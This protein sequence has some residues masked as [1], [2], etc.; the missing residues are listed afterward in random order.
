[1][2]R[3]PPRST[4]L[5]LLALGLAGS[6]AAQQGSRLWRPEERVVLTDFGM[7]DAVAADETVVYVVTRGG[8][9]VYDPRFQ[10]WLPPVTRVDGFEPQRTWAALV[11]P[12]DR[13]LWLGTELGLSNYAPLRQRF[14]SVWDGGA[15][16]QLMFDVADTFAGVY[17]H[18]GSDWLFLPRGGTIAQPARAL[19]SANRQVRTSTVEE[20]LRRFPYLSTMRARILTDQQMRTYQYTAAAAL[21]GGDEVFMGTDGLGLLR[22]DAAS[23][24]AEL[25]RF[26]LLGSTAGGLA[27]APG[28]VWVGS[29]GL[30]GRSGL[31]FVGSEL[32]R[33]EFVEGAVNLGPA[34]IVRDL[35]Y[36]AGKLWAAAE[37]GVSVVAGGREVRRLASSAGL[38]GDR[39][40]SLAAAEGGV[41]AGTE[42]GLAFI[43]DDGSVARVGGYGPGTVTALA[44]RGDTI[45]VGT[46]SGMGLLLPGE[47]RIVVTSDVAEVAELGRPIVALAF[48][49]GILVVATRDGIVWR[50][51][52]TGER[53]A[54]WT[55]ERPVSGRLGTLTAL[56][57]D[58]GGVWLGGERGMASYRYSTRQ[59]TF[60]D[61]LGDLPGVVRD[62]AVDEKYLWVATD[63][64]LVRFAR[65]AV[66]Q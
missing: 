7:V 1:M 24:E 15:V 32:Q 63:G 6:L 26:G 28:G 37:A 17:L 49:D 13:S 21:P 9:G 10:R 55:V 60:F 45:W 12:T 8:I 64:G 54:G 56:V 23:S 22:F 39:A 47:D 34:G 38:P 33:F 5:L 29:S 25:L 42:R 3:P 62:L 2:I 35:C 43:A 52:D 30:T 14:E 66:E 40:Y 50:G 41:W 57:G 44:A 16:T 20:V 27:L 48:S 11:D 61:T 4:S 65:D 19:P 31:T 58:A 51:A 18:V 36:H 46:P 53:G 59:F